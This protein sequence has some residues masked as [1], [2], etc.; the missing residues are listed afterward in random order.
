M[1]GHDDTSG[2]DEN[3][4]EQLILKPFN[5]K[6]ASDS[7]VKQEI[8][9]AFKKLGKGTASKIVNSK[10]DDGDTVF[11]NAEKEAILNLFK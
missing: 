10:R 11:S 2:P 9:N 6:Y 3:Q 5:E 8:E 4:D 7:N 1:G